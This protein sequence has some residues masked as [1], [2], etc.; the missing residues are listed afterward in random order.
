MPLVLAL[1]DFNHN[2]RWQAAAALN[3]LGWRPGN[4][5]E[6]VMRSVA[7]GQHEEAAVHGPEAVE[8]L[9]HALEDRTCPRRHAAAAAL[10]KT[11]DPRAVGPL[12][13]ALNDEDSHRAGRG[14]RGAQPD[15]PSPI[16]QRLA[17]TC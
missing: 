16:L 2:V 3:A 10:G 11:A 5:A 14:G 6:F 12:E 9:I 13:N 8:M 17:R 7:I 1:K 15:W 4:N